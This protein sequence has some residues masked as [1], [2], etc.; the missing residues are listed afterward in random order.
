M[1]AH[2]AGVPLEELVAALAGAGGGLVAARAWL[3]VHVRRRG[4]PRA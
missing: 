1:I 3:A 2:V 4:G